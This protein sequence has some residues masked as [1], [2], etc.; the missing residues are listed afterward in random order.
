[1]VCGCAGNGDRCEM[2]ENYVEELAVG[3]YASNLT[4]PGFAS[5]SLSRGANRCVAEVFWRLMDS[6]RASESAN[7]AGDAPAD[8]IA[9]VRQSRGGDSEAY[10]R[11]VERHQEY[12]GQIMW[13]FSRDRLVH[14]ELVQDVFAE[15]Y[16]SIGSYRGK[17]PFGHWL[18]CIATR[19]G[20]RYWK[21]KARENRCERFSIEEWDE[22]VD[23]RAER[24]DATSA[25][26]LVHRFLTRLGPRDRLV[27]T[28][29]YLEGCDVAETARRTG[30]SKT[31][32]KVQTW[33]AMRKIE[34][35]FGEPGKEV[36]E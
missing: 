21:R 7:R 36:I 12:V 35:L 23:E 11:L 4:W 33:R 18:A 27:V 31:M 16:L 17:A 30:W 22:I 19:A 6:V 10:R 20:Y 34:K 3:V 14:E 28:L 2:C 1:M 32:V 5:G 13:R 25:A 26:S 24:A 9:D 15:A 29:R 8:D